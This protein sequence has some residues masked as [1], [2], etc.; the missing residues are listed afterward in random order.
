[1]KSMHIIEKTIW[2]ILGVGAP[3]ISYFIEC[4]VWISLKGDASAPL[5]LTLSIPIFFMLL[6]FWT[7]YLR[8]FFCQLLIPD[9][10]FQQQKWRLWQ[11]SCGLL[12]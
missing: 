2:M 9:P 8:R 7:F 3:I 4:L 12:S 10:D 6:A 11:I 1:M 5:I